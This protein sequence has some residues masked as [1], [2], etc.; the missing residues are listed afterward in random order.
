MIH[1]LMPN[2]VQ[3]DRTYASFKNAVNA[4]EVA[5]TKTSH[6]IGDVR[7]TV[8]VADDGRFAPV[9]IGSND[10]AGL[11]NLDFIHIGVTVVG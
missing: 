2:A 3:T 11:S 7:W 8:G 9:V 1:N 6:N 4:L 10:R 5:I